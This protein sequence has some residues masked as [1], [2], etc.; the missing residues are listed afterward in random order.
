MTVLVFDHGSVEAVRQRINTSD[1][2]DVI[3]VHTFSSA[4]QAV[5]NCRALIYASPIDDAGVD[6]L[7][8]VR[9]YNDRLPVVVAAADPNLA[10]A[11]TVLRGKALALAGDYISLEDS[12][13]NAKLNAALE[14]PDRLIRNGL[15]VRQ[16]EKHAYY[17]GELLPLTPTEAVLLAL[18]LKN[19]GQTLDWQILSITAYGRRLPDEEAKSKMKTHVF[20]LRRKLQDA[21][22]IDVIVNRAGYGFVLML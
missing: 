1:L 18:F 13:F 21:I 3:Y 11:V 19:P 2:T 16:K 17:N 5:N 7:K 8:S 15:E 14:P 6:F 20:N 10:D 4:L 22:G 9:S 12:Q